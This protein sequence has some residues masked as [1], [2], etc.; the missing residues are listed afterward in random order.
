MWPPARIM[1]MRVGHLLSN[2]INAAVRGVS[3]CVCGWVRIWAA[4]ILLGEQR[5]KHVYFICARAH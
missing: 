3:L 5:H 4:V 2:Q 1:H